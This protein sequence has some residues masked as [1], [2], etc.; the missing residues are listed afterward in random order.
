[1]ESMRGLRQREGENLLRFTYLESGRDGGLVPGLSDL[2]VRT[3]T[4]H[5]CFWLLFSSHAQVGCPK[6][7]DVG[8]S[9]LEVYKLLLSWVVE[10][11][12]VP[13]H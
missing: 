3:S 12:F 10:R 7:R 6:I 13:Q 2:R 4:K 11:A 5:S 8:S 9:E 1:M